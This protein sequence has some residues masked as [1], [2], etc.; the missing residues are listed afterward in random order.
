MDNGFDTTNIVL[1]VGSYS[2][3][4]ITRDTF[5]MA[6]KATCMEINGEV[7]PIYKDPKTD[8][9]TKKSARGY[10]DVYKKDG[11][12]VLIQN[13]ASYDELF[14]WDSEFYTAFYDGNVNFRET[15]ETVTAVASVSIENALAKS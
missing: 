6:I 7:V 8:N 3:Q 14:G 1:G 10:L 5:G 2:L 13:V 9:G 15:W 12:Y 11:E 4:Y